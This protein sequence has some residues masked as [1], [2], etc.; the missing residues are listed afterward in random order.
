MALQA[1][2]PGQVQQWEKPCSGPPEVVESIAAALAISAYGILYHVVFGVE[3]LKQHVLM[4]V[5]RS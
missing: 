2:W 1:A 4:L 3:F 5:D